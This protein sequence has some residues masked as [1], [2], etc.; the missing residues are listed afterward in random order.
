VIIKPRSSQAVTK[1]AD[2][3]GIVGKARFLWRPRYYLHLIHHSLFGLK[4]PLSPMKHL[5]CF[6][7]FTGLLRLSSGQVPD[8]TAGQDMMPIGL[9]IKMAKDLAFTS[10]DL[11]EIKTRYE[12][13][14]SDLKKFRLIHPQWGSNVVAVEERGLE[15][16]LLIVNWEME[17]VAENNS[18][19]PHGLSNVEAQLRARFHRAEM[20]QASGN[21]E[22]ARQEFEN[23]YNDW[24]ALENMHPAWEKA[25]VWE[26]IQLCS[27]RIRH[28]ERPPQRD[29]R[30][31]D[32]HLST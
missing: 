29:Y 4:V 16:D 28:F 14:L 2:I 7:Y 8:A 11:P 30:A 27:S 6:L 17:G 5:L 19:D 13:A 20:Y 12:V 1:A 24:L 15:M 26:K 21:Y 10:W 9:E 25:M 32:P 22:A 23:C 3:Q 31:V 18:Q